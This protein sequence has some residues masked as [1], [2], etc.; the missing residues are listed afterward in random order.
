MRELGYSFS[1]VRLLVILSLEV[2][3]ILGNPKKTLE[4][5]VRRIMKFTRQIKARSMTMHRQS[6]QIASNRVL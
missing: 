3:D 5:I 4:M 6:D 1:W 2:L